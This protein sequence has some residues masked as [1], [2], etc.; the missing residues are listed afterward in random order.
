MASSIS[1]E[2]TGRNSIQT[3]VTPDMPLM[4]WTE[5]MS[6]GVKVLDDDHK[7]L[8]AML[9]ELHDSIQ[10][11]RP[12]AVLERVIDGMLKYTKT[13]FAREEKMFAQTGYPAAAAH[14]AEHEQLARR[15][16]NLQSRF[17]NGQSNVLTLETVTFIQSW[18]KDHIMGSD[19]QY[20]PHFK[21]KGI[22]YDPTSRRSLV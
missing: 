21:V 9:N 22:E 10:A 8:I 3:E 12:R 5:E 6:V 19:Q 18:L 14:K 15:A 1:H 13:H 20:K 16:M 2:F 4:T 7:A 11:G 17:E